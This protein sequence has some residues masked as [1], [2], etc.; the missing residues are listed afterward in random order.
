MNE[1]LECGPKARGLV[2]RKKSVVSAALLKRAPS[3]MV[4][5]FMRP[6]M[7]AFRCILLGGIKRADTLM[8][9]SSRSEGNHLV[10]RGRRADGWGARKN[11]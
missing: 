3:K 10:G 6:S 11:N 7:H 5:N 2:E 8:Y 4:S 1:K 9:D